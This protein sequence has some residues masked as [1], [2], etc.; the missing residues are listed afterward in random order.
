MQSYGVL[1]VDTSESRYSAAYG[2][3]RIKVTAMDSNGCYSVYK[4]TK[5]N[6]YTPVSLLNGQN[7]FSYQV[8]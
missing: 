5:I 1:I 2:V 6:I 4:E 7:T 8:Y 3:Y